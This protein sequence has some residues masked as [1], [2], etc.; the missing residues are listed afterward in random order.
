M[1]HCQTI[2]RIVRSNSRG[3]II[4]CS[5]R[6]M[7][8]GKRIEKLLLYNES[9]RGW[10]QCSRAMKHNITHMLHLRH[11]TNNR[12]YTIQQPNRTHLRRSLGLCTGRQVRFINHSLL[13]V[14]P[15]RL[16]VLARCRHCAGVAH[17]GRLIVTYGRTTGL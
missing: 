15:L 8:R 10:G 7:I 12:E 3:V 4:L 13:P 9:G 11:S 16:F 17:C 2:I 14:F 1:L 5:L 6:S